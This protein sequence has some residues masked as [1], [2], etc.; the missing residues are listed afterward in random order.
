[1]ADYKYNAWSVQQLQDEILRVR[2]INLEKEQEL[3]FTL[4]EKAKLKNDHSAL[5]FSYTFLASL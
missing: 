4:T 2:M 5:A 3:C 1:M